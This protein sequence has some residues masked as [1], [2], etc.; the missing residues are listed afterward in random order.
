MRFGKLVPAADLSMI[1]LAPKKD[2]R[3]ADL[4][5]MDAWSKKHA[6]DPRAPGQGASAEMTEEQQV[7]LM[8]WAASNSDT[9]VAPL[10]A[11]RGAPAAYTLHFGA[12]KGCT[13][14]QLVRASKFGGRASI[15]GDDG[16]GAPEPGDYL[17]WLASRAFIWTF[18]YHV[19]LYIA[20]R[21]LDLDSCSVFSKDAHTPLIMCD[22]AMLR[23]KEYA[24]SLMTPYTGERDP[25]ASGSG[26]ADADDDGGADSGV[27][28]EGGEEEAELES[29]ADDED[30]AAEGGAAAAAGV[31]GGATP[32]AAR[33]T[34]R[35]ARAD[36]EVADDTAH[37]AADGGDGIHSPLGMAD[38]ICNSVP[39]QQ[40]Q[41]L[42]RVV[43][44]M[45]SGKR[46]A[47][48]DMQRLDVQPPDPICLDSFDAD[49]YQLMSIHFWSPGTKFNIQMPCKNHGWG[50]ATHM[51]T[52]S[53]WT[54]RRV[55]GVFSDYTIAGQ[56]MECSE[57]RTEY[58]RL[59]HVIA[60]AKTHNPRAPRIAALEAQLKASS[61]RS[62]TLDPTVN[63]LL[64]ERYPH[65]AIK[66][67]AVLSHRKAVSPQLMMMVARAARTSQ[68][69][70]DLEAALREF[71]AIASAKQRLSFF[72]QQRH[73]LARQ[74]SS[75]DAVIKEYSCGISQVSDTYLS[76][77]LTSFYDTHEKYMMQWSEQQVSHPP[78]LA[79]P[80]MCRA[81]ARLARV[82]SFALWTH[83]RS[84]LFTS[85]ATHPLSPLPPLADCARH[86]PQRPP[87]QAVC[88]HVD[89]WR[90]VTQLAIYRLQLA[91]P[92]RDRHQHRELLIQRH[93]ARRGAPRRAPRRRAPWPC[94]AQVCVVR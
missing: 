71:R 39:S 51:C 72:S 34:A 43:S 79:L 85:T 36:D 37:D 94:A 52:Y 64:F 46:L 23:Y 69:S 30:G 92:E 12:Y 57:C 31:G 81:S 20:L 42:E 1:R 24:R 3:G 41:F 11:R 21:Q 50:H 83:D 8:R 18:P 84:L 58:M 16:S 48:E 86:G 25:Y 56:E 60:A 80:A 10:A 14:S 4:A 65:V 66:M 15:L 22:E 49:S 5:S 29:D 47:Y 62:S 67:P 63:K 40:K 74:W 54:Q 78:S 87:R 59:K 45:A 35:A 75:D 2:L 32:R 73:H 13:L 27:E 33:A 91:R 61:Y 7:T 82:M 53:R 88:A 38:T 76:E 93:L 9:F 44:D 26:G 68:G 70:H 77:M 17:L 28:V 89:P 90:A 55:C 6:P 19:Y